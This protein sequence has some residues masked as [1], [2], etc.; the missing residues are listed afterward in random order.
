[1]RFTLKILCFL[2][3]VLVL[4][5]YVGD[6]DTWFHLRIGQELWESKSFVRTEIFSFP[7]N[8]EL[9]LNHEWPFQVVLFGVYS[10]GG[11]LT[12]AIMVAII[13]AATLSLLKRG[14]FYISQAILIGFIVLAIRP[15]IVPRPQVLAYLALA[16]LLFFLDRYARSRSKKDLV[17][18]AGILLIWSNAHASIILAL[19]ILGAYAL[20]FLFGSLKSLPREN[21]KDFFI[22]CFFGLLLTLF[23]PLFYNVYAQALQPLKYGEVYKTLIE[24][25]SLIGHLGNFSGNFIFGV[26]VVLGSMLAWLCVRRRAD[27]WQ[28]YLLGI[29]FWV[30]P[31]ASIKYTPFSW[32]V[33]MPII[34]RILPKW[35]PGRV[36]KI[37]ATGLVFVGALIFAWKVGGGTTDAHKEWPRDLVRFV[38]D[39]KLQGKMFNPLSLGGYLMWNTPERPVFIWG[40]CDCFYDEQYFEAV[41]FGKGE[42]VDELIKKYSFDI[43]LVRPWESLAYSLSIKPDWALVYWDN[44]GMIFVRRGGGNEAVIK[45]HSLEIPYLNDTIEATF[46]KVPREKIPKLVENYEEAIRRKPDLILGRMYAGSLHQALGRCDLAIP[47]WQSIV[48]HK[49]NLGVAHQK[50]AECYKTA[51]NPALY[52]KESEL[53]S[54]FKNQGKLWLGRP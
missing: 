13:G 2:A 17:F 23:N 53:A 32:I 11:F 15:F 29:V 7:A 10:A 34:L 52:K 43:A 33:V 41:D 46:R 47:H 28:E 39:Q 14:E 24:T 49:N 19:P 4:I 35:E 50:L 44:F 54:R 45:K 3:L 21:K 25:R 22:A 16:A 1:M 20:D 42:H 30:A 6:N 18:V 12:V 27:G 8:G 26:H 40:G 48:D 37:T 5:N 38:E 51:N 9:W 36:F 31:L